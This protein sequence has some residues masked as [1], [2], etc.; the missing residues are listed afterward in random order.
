MRPRSTLPFLVAC[1]LFTDL[2]GA[3]AQEAASSEL[4]AGSRKLMKSGDTA[5]A[6]KAAQGGATE[7][8]LG[9]LA[10]EKASNADVKA[11][12]QQMVDEH[13][14]ANEQL[15]SIA[16][17]QHLTLPSEADPKGQAMYFKLQN[18]PAAKFD[19]LYLKMMASDHR[20]DV[21]SF[22]KEAK[23]GADPALKD[24]AAKTLPV[25]EGHLDKAKMIESNVGASK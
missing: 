24:F 17:S 22:G 4:D 20:A 9:Q 2:T 7:I 11:L 3:W 16:Q 25:L 13:T 23:N 1:V 6:I 12:G 10:S 5:F 19:H 14:K 21:K 18:T 8:K 15:R